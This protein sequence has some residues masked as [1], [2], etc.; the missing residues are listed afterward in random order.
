MLPFSRTEQFALQLLSCGLTT[1]ELMQ[2]MTWTERQTQVFRRR[3]MAA[4]KRTQP[5]NAGR[6]SSD[7]S[8]TT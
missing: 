5:S 3:V 8:P 2:A 7:G 4:L 6:P 1:P